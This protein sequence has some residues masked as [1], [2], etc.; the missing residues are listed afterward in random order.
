MQKPVLKNVYYRVNH[1]IQGVKR[2]MPGGNTQ[3]QVDLNFWGVNISVSRQTSSDRPS[4]L[5]VIVPRAEFKQS[6]QETEPKSCTTEIVLSSIT[7]VISPKN[8]NN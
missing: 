8:L 1:M 4:E 7:I 2:R 3:D 5:S 6:C